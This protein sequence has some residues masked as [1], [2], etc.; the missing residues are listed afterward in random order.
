MLNVTMH[1]SDQHTHIA[2]AFWLCLTVYVSALHRVKGVTTAPFTHTGHL[3]ER[4]PLKSCHVRHTVE[5][6]PQ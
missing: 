3:Q 5:Q 1:G 4:G 6:N 2:Y